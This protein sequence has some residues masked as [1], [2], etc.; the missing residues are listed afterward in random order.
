MFDGQD[1]GWVDGWMDEEDDDT[2]VGDPLGFDFKS[3]SFKQ[4]SEKVQNK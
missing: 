2:Q 1:R 4:V 3:L